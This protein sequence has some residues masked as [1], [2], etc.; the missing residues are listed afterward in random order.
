[1]GRRLKKEAVDG[2]GAIGTEGCR[3]RGAHARAAFPGDPGVVSGWCACADEW[4]G[5]GVTR[6]GVCASSWELRIDVSK[7]THGARR[8]WVDA[9]SFGGRWPRFSC[10]RVDDIRLRRLATARLWAVRFMAWV[11][12]GVARWLESTKSAPRA[13]CI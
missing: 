11:G 5:R 6:L 10:S 9:W 13:P 12:K 4:A 8:R 2:D 3:S 1:V 7:V